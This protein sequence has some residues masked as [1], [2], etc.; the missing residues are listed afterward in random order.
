M[1]GPPT[2]HLH[3]TLLSQTRTHTHIHN[4]AARDAN[5]HGTL[6]SLQM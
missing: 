1:T 5:D 6:Y 4:R 2:A 3:R